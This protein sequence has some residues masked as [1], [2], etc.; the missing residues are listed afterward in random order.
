MRHGSSASRDPLL[1]PATCRRFKTSPERPISAGQGGTPEDLLRS[2]GFPAP[3]IVIYPAPSLR[4]TKHVG[5]DN[6][7]RGSFHGQNSSFSSSVQLHE[8]RLFEGKATHP[9]RRT[10]H[11][12]PCL[13]KQRQ[14]LGTAFLRASAHP[15]LGALWAS[16]SLGHY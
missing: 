7:P 6:H 12:P 14:T 15:L 5:V 2:E 10:C 8:S 13:L 11:P 1:H 16:D 4:P 9:T 3:W